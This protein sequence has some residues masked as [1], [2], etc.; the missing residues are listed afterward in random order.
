[1][2]AGE[3][4]SAF[5]YADIVMTTTHKTLRGTRGALIFYK[6]GSKKDKKGN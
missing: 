4:P 3:I 5:E 6:V 1:M 2:A